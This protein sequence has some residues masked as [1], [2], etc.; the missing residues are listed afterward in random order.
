MERKD[1][2][3]PSVVGVVD[4]HEDTAVFSGVPYYNV[5]P[6]CGSACTLVEQIISQLRSDAISAS[7]E[8]RQLLSAPILLDTDA[9]KGPK[10]SKLDIGAA[11]RLGLLKDTSQNA[12]P[13]VC[14]CVCVCVCV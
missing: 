11:V 9:L 1:F 3:S 2:L 4:H 8:V 13:G 6:T 12:D 14:V 5:V 7:P 10:T